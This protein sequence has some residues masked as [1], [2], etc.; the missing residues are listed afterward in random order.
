MLKR[1]KLIQGIGS[2]G[3]ARASGFELAKVNIFY[4]E[5]RNGKSTLCDILHSL[6]ANNPELVLNRKAIPDDSQRPPKVELLFEADSGNHEVRFENAAWQNV[7]PECSKLYVFDQS[8]IHRN[9]ITGQK[10]DRQNSENVTS[11]IL[12][13]ANT[14]LYKQLAELKGTVRTERS[15]LAE[16]EQQLGSNGITSAEEYANTALPAQNKQELEDQAAIQEQKMQLIATTLQNVGAIQTRRVLSSVAQQIDYN[17][18]IETINSILIAS[19]QDVHHGALFALNNHVSSHV[20]NPASFKGWAA[21]GLG[22]IKNDS[23]P[24]CAQKLG[25]NEK[26]LITTY[27]Q[28]FNTKF[29][30]FNSSTKQTLDQ[31]RQPF[32][33]PDSKDAISQLHLV[34]KD[35]IS[36]YSEPQISG[37]SSLPNLIQ[38]LDQRFLELLSAYDVLDNNRQSAMDF[39][40]PILSQK[41][42]APYEPLQQIDFSGLIESMVAY[43][44]AIYSYWQICEQIN[45]LLNQFK[46]S[47][48]TQQ[49]QNEQ[50]QITQ[51]HNAIQMLIKRIALEPLCQQYREKRQHLSTAETAYN[52]RKEELE[53]SQSVYLENYFD[54]VNGLFTEL[55]SS[56]FEILKV[57]NNRGKQIVYELRVK[58]KGRPIPVEKVN[59]VFSESDRRALALCIFLAK[60][61][62]L[63]SEEKQKAIL[64]FDDPVTSFD[65]ERITL[66][67]NKLDEL[68][69]QVKQLIV[70]THYKGMASKAIKKFY[71]VAKSIRLTHT[72][73]GIDIALVEN[74]AMTASAHDVAFDR[75]KAFVDR[76][77]N[78]NIIT[79]LRPFLEQEIRIRY[80]KQLVDLGA[81]QEDLSVCIN[82]L[83]ERDVISGELATQLHTLRNSLN[84]PMHEI[85][86]D[87]L[88][89]TRSVARQILDVVYNGLTA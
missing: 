44:Q 72:V 82:K 34:N 48:K 65:N 45:E 69:R 19:L 57:P 49:L 10:Q 64:I 61:L 62:S 18:T 84:I 51:N 81:S 30:S 3:Q 37:N 6:E 42:N 1:I 13:E 7:E 2:Y 24:F 29:D 9:V 21:Q 86:Q 40:F 20:N 22:F 88:E 17:P 39:W 52:Q 32:L 43:N 74:S 73:N 36:T 15:N 70:T 75:I 31:L 35:T 26:G 56:D 33:I 87:A 59:Y 85:G 11:F 41:Y 78:D 50:S 53:L 89:N 8:F 76:V 23:C 16:I 55:G 5:N 14:A 4:G 25:D 68:Q 80:K 12:G 54:L 66:I 71:Q 63:S 47:T 83:Q 27:Q 46:A 79:E 77:T 58:F 28:V 60:I 67:L 38:L